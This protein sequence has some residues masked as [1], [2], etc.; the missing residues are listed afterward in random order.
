MKE[1]VRVRSIIY[2]IILLLLIGTIGYAYLLEVPLLD[3]LYMTIIT[4][5]TVGYR[6]VADL[7]TAGKLFTMG[8]ILSGLGIVAYGVSKAT[9]FITEGEFRLVL[10]ERRNRRRIASMKDH[11]IIC[12]AGQ[13]TNSIIKQFTASSAPFVIIEQDPQRCEQLSENGHTVVLGDATSEQSLEQAGIEHAKG[14]ISAL[15]TDAENVFTV[16]TA[17]TMN[18]K[19][20]IVSKAID[21]SAPAKLKK[22]GADSTISPNELGGN[23]MAFLMLKPQVVSFLETITHVGE[24]SMNIG[25]ITIHADSPISGRRLNEIRIPEKTGLIVIAIKSKDGKTTFNPSSNKMLEPESSMLVLGSAEQISKLEAIATA[26]NP[27][28]H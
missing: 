9:A 19:I 24:E 28:D 4:V 25:E 27:S 17:R 13:T 7:D 18:P 20:Q 26:Q 12:G 3:A 22:A 21:E 14:L 23:R 10:R 15:D 11:Y 6:E 2:L 16:L 5:S 1:R 8:I